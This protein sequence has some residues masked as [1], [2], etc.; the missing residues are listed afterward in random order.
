MKTTILR[1]RPTTCRTQA[2]ASLDDQAAL[3]AIS[4]DIARGLG[5]IYRPHLRADD[6]SGYIL[7]GH[8]VWFV[9]VRWPDNA[10]SWQVRL[11]ARWVGSTIR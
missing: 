5:S 1:Y 10:E 6:W 4:E 7:Q 11:N 3:S 9:K 2:E 8:G